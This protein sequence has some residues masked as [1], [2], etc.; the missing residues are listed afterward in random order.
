MPEL[1]EVETVRRDLRRC[2]LG[3]K[4]V[5]VE[6]G[7]E[8]LVRGVSVKGFK[9]YLKGKSFS[10]IDRRGKLLVFRFKRGTRKTLLV[11]LKMTGQLVYKSFKGMVI[12]GHRMKNLGELP[13]KYSHIILD[14]EDGSR[15]FFNDLRQFGYWKLV[16]KKELDKI[17]NEFGMEPLTGS[18]KWEEFRK[19]VKDRRRQVKAFLLDQKMVAGIGNIYSDEICFK[20]GIRPNRKLDG[21]DEEKVKILYKE[22][23]KVLRKAI[24]RKGTSYGS[25]S[26]FL[27]VYGRDGKKCLICK[28]GRIR[29]MNVAGRKSRYCP[30]CQF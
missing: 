20:T 29:K 23:T 27:K 24:E 16:K 12:G 30:I 17:L 19:L 6:V 4:I 18:F 10:E 14:F 22:I 25:Y 3:K 28:K 1:P 26:R 13:G 15:L 2:I 5:Q 7:K 21:L 8:K 11:H 9:K